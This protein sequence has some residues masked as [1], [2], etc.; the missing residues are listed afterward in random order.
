MINNGAA[1]MP[2]F[3]GNRCGVITRIATTPSP[4]AP[5]Y[6]V[7]RD[8]LHIDALAVDYDTEAFLARFIKRWPPG[9]P[10]YESYYNRIVDGPDFALAQAAPRSEQMKLSIIMPVLNEAASIEAALTALQL[11]RARGV[12]VIVADGG[13]S[14]GTVMLARTLTDRV[15]SAP[16]GRAIQMNAGAA[17]ASGDVLLFLH[18]DTHLPDDADKLVL[19]GLAQSKRQW[20]RF[21]VR[22]DGGGLLPLIAL[23]M[24]TRSRLTSICT[25][26]QAMFM[27]RA[28]FDQAGG[29]PA[30]ALMEDVQLSATLKRL[31]K[32]LCLGARAV[33]SPRRWHKHGTLRTMMLMW[34]LRLAYYCGADPAKLAR[35]YGYAAP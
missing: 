2:N 7:Q 6:G 32:P 3:K 28:A 5:L 19:D 33:T 20:G 14:D 12:E 1:G 18:A 25:G 22:I 31:G 8:G 35:A 17:A 15:V 10:A 16:R 24:N 4:H 26:D 23:M 29:F 30:I 11:Y 21:D 27:T 9:S 34:R 13:S